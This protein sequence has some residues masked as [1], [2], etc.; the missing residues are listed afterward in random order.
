MDCRVRD[1]TMHYEQVGT[2]RPLLILDGWGSNARM[3]QAGFEPLFEGR[4]GWR[5]LYPDLPGHGTTPMPEWVQGPDDVLW[6]LL[7]FMDAVAPGEGFVVAGASWGAYLARGLIHHRPTSVG[8]V[9][10]DIPAFEFGA[11]D[12]EARPETIIIRSDPDFVAALEPS[13]EWMTGTLVVQTREVLDRARAIFKHWAPSDPAVKSLLG[14]K[15]FSFDPAVL[16]E[17]FHAPALFVMGRQDD[18]V[19]YLKAWS[20]LRDYP[21]ATFAVLDRA[22]HLL[23]LEQFALQHAL[24]DEWLDRV[25]EYAA[26]VPRS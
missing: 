6:V 3:A 14:G 5:R 21:R 18:S 15:A 16:D 1:M 13:E 19:G 17:P 12:R 11:V 10:F 23:D 24:V 4:S 25:E 2:G 22:G 20:V 7:E 8:G 9:L 26:Q